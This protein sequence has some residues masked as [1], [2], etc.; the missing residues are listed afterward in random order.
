MSCQ[1]C[2]NSASMT[3]TQTSA[4]D[5]VYA[6]FWPANL[7]FPPLTPWLAAAVGRAEARQ[8]AIDIGADR[9]PR[10]LSGDPQAMLHLIGLAM[11][12]GGSYAETRGLKKKKKRGQGDSD[13]SSVD[14]CKGTSFQSPLDCARTGDINCASGYICRPVPGGF[15][16]EFCLEC[17]DTPTTGGL[18]PAETQGA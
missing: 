13:I 17:I 3:G 1:G 15:G 4:F 8:W 7:P 2:Q 9:D 16:W 18:D 11:A 6:N 12:G 5:A 14:P 10:I